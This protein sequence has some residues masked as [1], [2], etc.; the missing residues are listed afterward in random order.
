MKVSFIEK[1]VLQ[2][3]YFQRNNYLKKASSILEKVLHFRV[4]DSYQKESIILKRA[5]NLKESIMIKKY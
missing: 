4:S 5:F 3:L 1:K 2:E